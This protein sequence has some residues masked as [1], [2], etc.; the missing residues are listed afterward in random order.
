MAHF[1]H[2]FFPVLE[3]FPECEGYQYSYM[4]GGVTSNKIHIGALLGH[5]WPKKCPFMGVNYKWSLWPSC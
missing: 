3:T 2:N 1:S 5:F 4:S